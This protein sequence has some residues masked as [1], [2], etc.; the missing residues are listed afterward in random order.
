MCSQ[1]QFFIGTYVVVGSLHDVQNLTRGAISFCR[2]SSLLGENT[3]MNW[4]GHMDRERGR[5]K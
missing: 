1:L 2:Q 4:K 3:K 5:R